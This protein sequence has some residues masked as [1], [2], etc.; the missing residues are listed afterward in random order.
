MREKSVGRAMIVMMH[1]VTHLH[2]V[3]VVV[4]AAELAGLGVKP[5][6]V[7]ALVDERLALMG[8]HGEP[9]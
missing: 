5:V 4:V 3:L 9:P 7:D 1:R 2:P 8:S 6:P